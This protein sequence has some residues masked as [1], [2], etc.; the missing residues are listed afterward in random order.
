MSPWAQGFTPSAHATLRS[1]LVFFSLG[2][3]FLHP[4]L[5]IWKTTAR[6]LCLE[7]PTLH[8]SVLVPHLTKALPGENCLLLTWGNW[9]Q[10][11]TESV[12]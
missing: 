5:T 4:E 8:T 9:S 11:G 2:F 10:C 7:L 3:T 6:A 1:F 12:V